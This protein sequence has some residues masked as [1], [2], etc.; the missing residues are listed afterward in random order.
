MAYP[1][2]VGVDFGS[3]GWRASC[4]AGKQA[5]IVLTKEMRPEKWLI[6]EPSHSNGIGMAFPSIKSKIGTGAKISANGETCL[7]DDLVIEEFCA[8]RTKIE[9]LS[10]QTVGQVVI[11]VPAVYSASRRAAL[12]DAALKAGFKDAHLLNDSM[13]AV[14]SYTEQSKQSATLLVYGM[15]YAGFEIGL[16]RAVR[17]RYRALGYEAGDAPSGATWD[18]LILREWFTWLFNCFS[19]ENSVLDPH[20]NKWGTGLWM[21]VRLAA[22]QVKE[23]LSTTDEAPFRIRVPIRGS[24]QPLLGGVHRSGLEEAIA[25]SVN[26][27]L[28]LAEKMLEEA[29]L[30]SKDLDAVLLVGGS[31]RIPLIP[32]I[33]EKRLGRKPVMLDVDALAKGAALYAMRLET[34]PLPTALLGEEVKGSAEA[35]EIPATESAIVAT[36]TTLETEPV[37]PQGEIVLAAVPSPQ[38]R[39]PPTTPQQGAEVTGS[40]AAL[41]HAQWLI[42]QGE[43]SQAESFLQGLIK[44]AQTLL[45]TIRSLSTPTTSPN[46]ERAISRA[47]RLLKQGKYEEAVPQAHLAWQLAP[48]SPDIFDKMIDIHCQAAMAKTNI[49]DYALSRRWLECALSHDQSNTKVRQTLADRHYIHAKQLAE[50]GRRREALAAIELCLQCNPE[51]E[52]GNELNAALSR[53][54][55]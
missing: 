16:V 26:A 44:D 23:A 15:G 53:S 47:Y 27:T 12:R 50:R 5:V 8:L 34:M 11:S 42:E 3:L 35:V 9:A 1:I 13:S 43:H 37:Q 31:T 52:K 45:E 55:P 4:M 7:P 10:S 6:C 21:K 33:M 28:D 54:R 49:E 18:E 39:L 14:I 41:Q 46:A 17:G 25:P 2:N 30:S 22:Q 29:T 20:P 51:H 24:T 38:R 19:E 32:D 36:V 48:D 40:E